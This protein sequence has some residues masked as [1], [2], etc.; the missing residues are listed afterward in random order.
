MSAQQACDVG[1]LQTEQGEA[2]AESRDMAVHGVDVGAVVAGAAG[3][4]QDSQGVKVTCRS[5]HVASS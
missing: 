1:T 4:V 2:S 5:K 3:A